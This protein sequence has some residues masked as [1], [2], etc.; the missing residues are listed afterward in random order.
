MVS[1]AELSK[2]CILPSISRLQEVTMAVAAAVAAAAADDM[3][4][5]VT[6]DSTKCLPELQR[7]SLT[8]KGQANYNA[9]ASNL[10]ASS[11]QVIRAIQQSQ[12]PPSVD[13]VRRL[14]YIA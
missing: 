1:G 3:L 10:T 11:S 12:K 9:S 13:C 7:A 6:V 8:I 2:E 4:S 5:S 14:Q